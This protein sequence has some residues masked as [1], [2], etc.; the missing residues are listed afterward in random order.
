MYEAVGEYRVNSSHL[1]NPHIGLY[2]D[3]HKSQRLTSEPNKIGSLVLDMQKV[4]FSPVLNLKVN[5]DI[6][7][8]W[9][10]RKSG[11]Y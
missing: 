2:K 7:P 11:S 8:L 6:F 4:T 3:G 5:E 1:S 10:E 9:K